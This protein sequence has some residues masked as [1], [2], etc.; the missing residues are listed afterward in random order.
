[1]LVI[2]PYG[3]SVDVVM[4]RK[5]AKLLQ[6][7]PSAVVDEPATA[8]VG[9]GPPPP[10]RSPLQPLF[11]VGPG[12]DRHMA[13]ASDVES[14]GP[15]KLPRPLARRGDHSYLKADCTSFED[16]DDEDLHLSVEDLRRRDDV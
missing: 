13:G 11:S 3:S 5:R 10:R 8:G 4:Q 2:G 6:A 9:A 15:I 1:M 7:P 14:T 16:M 12:F